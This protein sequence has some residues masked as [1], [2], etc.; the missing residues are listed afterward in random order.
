VSRTPHGTLKASLRIDDAARDRVS[1][2]VVQAGLGL[3]SMQATSTGLETIFLELSGSASIPPTGAS[4]PSAAG[5][6]AAAGGA[7]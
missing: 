2:A 1:R 5:A 7:S 3:L 4:S 6:V